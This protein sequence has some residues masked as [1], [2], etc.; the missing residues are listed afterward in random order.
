VTGIFTPMG[1]S[2]GIENRGLKNKLYTAG[3]SPALT[4]GYEIVG[5]TPKTLKRFRIQ[6]AKAIGIWTPRAPLELNWAAPGKHKDPLEFATWTF[7]RYCV[8]WWVTTDASQVAPAALTPPQL[9]EAFDAAR[10]RVDSE[11]FCWKKCAGPISNALL[12][13]AE[14]GLTFWAG[15][16]RWR[17]VGFLSRSRDATLSTVRYSERLP[18]ELHPSSHGR[19]RSAPF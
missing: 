8:E 9:V 18:Q 2:E 13:L 7:R 15:H 10:E 3:A 14:S 17:L 4:F 5:F 16:Q 6:M 11:G 12:W 19:R 1:R